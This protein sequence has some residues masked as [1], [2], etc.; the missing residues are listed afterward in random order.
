MN[1]IFHNQIN[2]LIS[3]IAY[4]HRELPLRISLDSSL[5]PNSD[6]IIEIIQ[7][8][9]ELLFP[10]Y[11]GKQ[12]IINATIE[13][14]IGEV[15]IEIYEKLSEQVSRVLRHHVNPNNPFSGSVEQETERII[16]EFLSKIPAIRHVLATDVQAAF[17]GD[18]SAN[19]V[20]EIIFSYPGIFAAS[21]YRLAHELYVLKV[22]LIPRFMT[23]YAHSVT[24]IDIHAGAT[25]GSS[26]FIDHGT[27]VVIGETTVIGDR[28]KIYH[29]VTL[30][31]LSLRGGQSLNGVKRH[32]TLE[33]D[34]T[35]Y[36]GASILGGETVIGKGVVIGSNVSIS[37]S[38]P[39]GAKVTMKNPELIIQGRAP[40]EFTQDP[41]GDWVI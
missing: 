20:D 28:V 37:K 25:I 19:S 30:G 5:L 36:S 40:Q 7:L 2:R 9:R 38:V 12:N 26:F 1:N 3:E 34:V 23:E 35:I 39:A 4:S 16:Y 14:R 6:T 10:G 18:P 31:A 22:P 11:F 17:D 13:Y 32:P 21:I 8:L 33:D 41:I 15:L 27:G 29:G 24:G